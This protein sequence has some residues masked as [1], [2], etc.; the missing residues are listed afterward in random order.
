MTVAA[1]ERASKFSIQLGNNFTP[2]ARQ[3]SCIRS[4]VLSPI[5][6]KRLSR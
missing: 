3:A 6:T 2:S 1:G 5:V 4:A